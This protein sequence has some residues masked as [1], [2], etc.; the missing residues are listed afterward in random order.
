M[1]K[2]NFKI[3]VIGR[4][5]SGKTSLVRKFT[6]NKFT[7]NYNMTIGV[8]FE[9]AEINIDNQQVQLQIWDTVAL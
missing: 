3:I 7:Q 2:K 8:E 4:A 9:S 1:A 6:R 5:G